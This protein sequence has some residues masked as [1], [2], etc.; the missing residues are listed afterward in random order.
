MLGVQIE[1]VVLNGLVIDEGACDGIRLVGFECVAV[2]QVGHDQ[3]F[4][5]V[6][7]V[8]EGSADEAVGLDQVADEGLAEREGLEDEVAAARLVDVE[9]GGGRGRREADLVAEWVEELELDGL[10]D[11]ELGGAAG[12]VGGVQE[13]VGDFF[14]V[15]V[16]EVDADGVGDREARAADGVY[17][18]AGGD[19]DQVEVEQVGQGQPVVGDEAARVEVG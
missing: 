8:V 7:F 10:A 5:G 2:F 17:D 12:G 15:R 6:V 11:C 3:C 19:V 16:E 4:E 18:Q 9:A 13:C 14:D 1:H